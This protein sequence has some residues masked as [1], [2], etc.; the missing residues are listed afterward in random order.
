[1]IDLHAI[2]Q[3]FLVGLLGILLSPPVLAQEAGDFVVKTGSIN[4]DVYLVGGQVQVLAEVQGDVVVAG[5]QIRVERQVTG[6]ALLAGGSVEVRGAV[7]DDIRAAGGE[8]IVAGSVGG[9]ALLA[10]G[11]IKLTPDAAVGE[12]AWLAGGDVEMAGRVG[13]ELRIGAGSVTLS[14]EVKGN[15]MLAA[16]RITLL[17]TARIEGNLTY[18]SP[19]PADIPD[20]AQI[21]GIITHVRV[22]PEPGI[23]GAAGPLSRAIF[24]LGLLLVGIV[25]IKLFPRFSIAAARTIGCDPWKSLGL[26]L[27][28]LVTTPIAA[29]LLMATVIGIPL[30]FVALA[31]YFVTLLAGFLTGILF[32]GELVARRLGRGAGLTTRWK[33]GALAIAFIVLWFLQFFSGFGGLVSF[34]ALLFGLG[35]WTLH[36]YRVYRTPTHSS[37]AK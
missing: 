21:A 33:M 20:E 3:L 4:E 28:L 22:E 36:T 1:M 32:F 25:L 7:L 29:A 37:L 13:R 34:L 19:E 8:V 2:R 9:D 16:R 15:V 5:G 18:W 12:R 31:V 24:L 11:R 14:G 35:A 23:V 30:G 26:G 6:D 10:G 27:A 17:P